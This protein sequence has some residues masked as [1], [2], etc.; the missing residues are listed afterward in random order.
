MLIG[1]LCDVPEAGE[2]GTD[3][4]QVGSAKGRWGEV[5]NPLQTPSLGCSL[6]EPG[7]AGTVS[8]ALLSSSF[9]VPCSP[10]L[11][12]LPVLLLGVL[13]TGLSGHCFVSGFFHAFVELRFQ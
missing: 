10:G 3:R 5:G 2:P 12:S 1:G 4:A 6:K 7:T 9:L 8:P 13:F 11:P